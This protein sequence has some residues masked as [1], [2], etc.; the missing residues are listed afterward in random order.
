MFKSE[1]FE[2]KEKCALY[3]RGRACCRAGAR[4]RSVRENRKQHFCLADNYDSCP[5][6]LAYLLR[7]SQPKSRYSL[8]DE[9]NGK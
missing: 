9:F 8:H 7:H 3:E 4:P 1:N 6:Y 5:F 2:L